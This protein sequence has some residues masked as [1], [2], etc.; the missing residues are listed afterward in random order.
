[1]VTEASGELSETAPLVWP[2][3]LYDRPLLHSKGRNLGLP[4][5]NKPQGKATSTSEPLTL[6]VWALC[7]FFSLQRCIECDE[8][9]TDG[10]VS[11]FS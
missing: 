11:K 7:Q 8:A 1:M 5:G 2:Q 3:G 6:R 9:K 4:T 10:V